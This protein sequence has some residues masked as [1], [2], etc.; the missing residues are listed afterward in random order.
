MELGREKYV[1]NIQGKYE[2]LSFCLNEKSRRLWAATEAKSIGRGGISIVHD[3]TGIDFKTIRKGIKE[4][5]GSGQNKRVR[6]TGGGRKKLKDVEMNLVSDLQV[7]VDPVTR[8]DPESPLLWTCK[9][10]YKLCEE[11][12]NQGYNISQKTVYSLLVDMD[13]SLQSNRK[14]NEGKNHPDRDQQFR[15]ISNKVNLFL[16]KGNPVISVDTKKKENIGNFKNQGKEFQQKGKPIEVKV[17]D[18]LDKNLGKVAPYGVYDIG[19]NKGWVGVGISADTAEFAVNTI[20]NWWYIMGKPE[21]PNAN[22]ILITADG[23]G[24]NGYRVRLWK[25]E[26]QKFA[27]EVEMAISVCHFPPGTSKWNK[28]EH[29]MFSYITKNWRGRPLETREAVVQLIANTKTK[30]GLKI[31]AILD[32]NEYTKGKKIDNEIMAQIKLRKSIFHGEWNYKISPNN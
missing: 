10:T 4:L 3:A 19:K 26:L 23:G 11:L 22:E 16:K 21:Y 1:E 15:H 29:R 6:K 13:Y 5:E 14:R 17:H 32:E 20:R 12:N 28:I 8:G 7:L 27:N 30:T 2:Q 24:S 31:M 25:H 18:F 9:S